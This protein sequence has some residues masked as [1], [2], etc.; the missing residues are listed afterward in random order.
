MGGAVGGGAASPKPK[1]SSSGRRAS[2]TGSE[3]TAKL[4][5]MAYD[6]HGRLMKG[7]ASKVPSPA[8]ARSQAGNSPLTHRAADHAE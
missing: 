8:G 2:V 6:P 5:A 7:L 3:D 1:P 4:Q